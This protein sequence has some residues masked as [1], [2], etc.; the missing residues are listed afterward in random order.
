MITRTKRRRRPNTKGK[1]LVKNL[2]KTLEQQDFDHQ[3]TQTARHFGMS[4]QEVLTEI[5]GR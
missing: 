5:L 2:I 3:L 4:K 1:N